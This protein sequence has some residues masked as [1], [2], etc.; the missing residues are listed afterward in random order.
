MKFIVLSNGCRINVNHIVY[1]FEK[2][3]HVK[4]MQIVTSNQESDEYPHKSEESLES[5]E[6]KLESIRVEFT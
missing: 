1:Y 6:R 2:G 3:K 5:F 4:Y